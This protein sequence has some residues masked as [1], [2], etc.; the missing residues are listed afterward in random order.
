MKPG[1]HIYELIAHE[2]IYAIAVFTHEGECLFLN[3]V[4]EHM[5]ESPAT[6]FRLAQLMPTEDRAPFKNFHADFLKHEGLYQ[7]LIVRK[8]SGG[9]LIA[10]VGLRHIPLDQGQTGYLL[11]VQDVTLQKK[12]QREITQKQI[13]IKAAYED[14][15]RQNRQLKELDGAKD[16]FI[17]LTTHELRTPLSA[18]C[19]SVDILRQDLYDSPQQR[20]EFIEILHE[21]AHQLQTLVDDILDFAKIQAGKMDYHLE[22]KD[23]TPLAENV[24]NSF[25]PLAENNEVRLRFQAPTDCPVKRVC[26]FDEVRLRQILA[27]VMSNAIKFNRSKGQVDLRIKETANTVQLF[28]KDTGPG[29]S[30]KNF[31]KVF[32]EFET[33]E[34]MN[35]HQKGTGL[36][37]PISR[38]LAQGMGGDLTFKSRVGVGTTFRVEIPKNKVLDEAFYQERPVL[39]KSA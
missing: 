8:V 22:L 21:Q 29:I 20:K 33:V 26:Y 27:N 5:L 16:K 17:A 39:K 11:M 10:N 13:E 32:N 1:A 35:Q 14:L 9:Q 34:S 30:P 36:G 28:I 4:A 7:D 31:S 6:G 18:M 2:A 12:M 38:R 23:I 37:M 15:L 25:A 19:A 24:M 3:R